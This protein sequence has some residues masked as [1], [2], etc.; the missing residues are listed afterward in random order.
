MA[1]R[2]LGSVADTTVVLDQL[3]LALFRLH[4][5]VRKIPIEFGVLASLVAAAESPVRVG[6]ENLGEG[7]GRHASRQNTGLVV[8][9]QAVYML[10]G[11]I[12]PGG[13]RVE[14][15]EF[16][17]IGPVLQSLEQLAFGGVWKAYPSAPA[18]GR[19]VLAT[20]ADD[21]CVQ[22]LANSNLFQF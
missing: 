3:N 21:V 8:V 5:A 7:R 16:V 13:A 20:G 14:E 11:P 9:D 4:A 2:P 12:L 18:D 19:V 22:L 10:P 17:F 6:L 15:Q 1:P